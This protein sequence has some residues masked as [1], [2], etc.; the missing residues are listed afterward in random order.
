M[1]YYCTPFLSEDLDLDD[2]AS[3]DDAHVN[4]LLGDDDTLVVNTEVEEPVGKE[5]TPS[6]DLPDFE[7]PAAQEEAPSIDLPDFEEPATQE[8]RKVYITKISTRQ[9]SVFCSTM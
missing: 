7:E 9:G 5:E 3:I 4:A 2:F 6:F 1:I 8:E